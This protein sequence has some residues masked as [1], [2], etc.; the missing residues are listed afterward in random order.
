MGSFGLGERKQDISVVSVNE[1]EEPSS[2]GSPLK[3]SV[4]QVLK[5]PNE[6]SKRVSD[7]EDSDDTGA[8]YMIEPH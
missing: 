8:F 7:E 5:H 4:Q 6:M 1:T 3:S 2:R